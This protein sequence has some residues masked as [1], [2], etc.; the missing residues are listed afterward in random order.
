MT[1]EPQDARSCIAAVHRCLQ[2][3]DD[4]AMWQKGQHA[5]EA[6][7]YTLLALQDL[8]RRVEALEGVAREAGMASPA[9]PAAQH[10]G[11]GGDAH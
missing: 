8:V 9:A 10:T 2:A 4:A 3:L 6:V 7:G 11:E 5:T 1:G